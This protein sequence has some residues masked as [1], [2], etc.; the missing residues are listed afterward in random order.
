M[1]YI[2]QPVSIEFSKMLQNVILMHLLSVYLNS[3][4]IHKCNKITYLIPFE[5]VKNVCKNISK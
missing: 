5:I 2:L 1:Y 4:P 3:F